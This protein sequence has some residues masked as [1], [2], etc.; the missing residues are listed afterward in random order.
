MCTETMSEWFGLGTISISETIF[1]TS[2]RT[3]KALRYVERTSRR[4]SRSLF[5]AM[6]LYGPALEKRQLLLGRLVDVA[7]ELF[8]LTTS[9]LRADAIL[10]GKETCE[11]I[12]K[13]DLPTILAYLDARTRNRVR[14]LFEELS[15]P[16]DGKGRRLARKILAD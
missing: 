6:A 16:A 9:H 10:A 3:R 11:E 12:K 8:A 4:L 2:R 1:R 14:S 5:H 13:E 7:G 15:N